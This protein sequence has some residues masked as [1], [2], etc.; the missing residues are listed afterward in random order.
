MIV[1]KITNIINGKMYIGQTINSLEDR[2]LR[3]RND[4]LSNRLDTH[5]ARA[6]RKYGVDNFKVEIIDTAQS[7]DE[8]TDK[9]RYWIKYYNSIQ[10][11]YNE[12]DASY[13]SGGNTYKNKTAEEMIIIKEK[14]SKTK[15]GDKNPN[16]RKVKCFNVETGE[17]L[18]FN[19]IAD[20]QRYF[21]YNN[22]NFVTRR[23]NHSVRCLWQG[24]WKIAYEE[25]DYDPIV[26][27]EKNIRRATHINLEVLETGENYYFPSYAAA[28]RFFDLPIKSIS[29]KAYLK[30]ETFIF[31]DKYKITVLN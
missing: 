6:I 22:H 25:D 5:F 31:K 17:E 9:E 21:N 20:V 26:T 13:K 15:I 23:C 30:G 14:I 10:K 28:E 4:A 7:Q 19:T 12:T 2:W 27:V 18:H 29:S 11:G 3:H 16:T 1:Y 8:L 24:K